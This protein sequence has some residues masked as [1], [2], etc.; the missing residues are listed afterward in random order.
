[1]VYT[2][3]SPCFFREDRATLPHTD[4]RH[5]RQSTFAD[6]RPKRWFVRS[7]NTIISD[8]IKTQVPLPGPQADQD[9]VIAE[10][11]LASVIQ[12]L[13]SLRAQDARGFTVMEGIRG[14]LYF[15]RYLLQQCRPGACS[16][17][18]MLDVHTFLQGICDMGCSANALRQVPAVLGDAPVPLLDVRGHPML[19]AVA[20]KA[21]TVAATRAQA[22]QGAAT[23]TKNDGV[24]TAPSFELVPCLTLQSIG[25]MLECVV[26]QGIAE[27]RAGTLEPETL[28]AVFTGPDYLTEW[29]YRVIAADNWELATHLQLGSHSSKHWAAGMYGP[30]NDLMGDSAA[31]AEFKLAHAADCAEAE[32]VRSYQAPAQSAPPGKASAFG[33]GKGSAHGNKVPGHIQQQ[34]QKVPFKGG[35]DKAPPAAK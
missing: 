1:V 27:L 11:T 21:A 8:N 31:A 13:T 5:A 35:A 33:R 6:S 22:P 19:A 34:Q 20:A 3:D 29:N 4:W 2:P 17:E 25:S 26:T 23:E 9:V 10:P 12:E 28:A 14:K 18:N 30:Q 16:L 32:Q 7:G 15:P 24:L